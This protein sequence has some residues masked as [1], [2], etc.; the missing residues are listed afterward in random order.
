MKGDPSK[1]GND[2]A[3]R[4]LVDGTAGAAVLAVQPAA[5][6]TGGSAPTVT[7]SPAVLAP[8]P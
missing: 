4:A 6:T 5:P 1:R 8:V 2:Q 7:W 3:S